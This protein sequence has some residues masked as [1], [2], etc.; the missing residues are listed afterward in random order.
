MA[1]LRFNLDL[2]IPLN[3]AVADGAQPKDII[4]Q[5]PLELQTKI[6]GFATEIRRAKKYAVRINEGLANEEHTVTA[7]FHVC[8][9]DEGK[10]CELQEI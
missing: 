4:S 7:N 6:A 9:H 10:S 5:L 2:A 8:R 3:G 1:Y